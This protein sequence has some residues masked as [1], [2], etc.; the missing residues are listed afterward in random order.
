M[1]EGLELHFDY[2]LAAITVYIDI[3]FEIILETL[4]LPRSLG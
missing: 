4:R 2:T 1:I 3:D